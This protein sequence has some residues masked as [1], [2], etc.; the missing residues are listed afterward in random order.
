VPGISSGDGCLSFSVE[1]FSSAY[2]SFLPGP[3]DSGLIS[4]TRKYDEKTSVSP[5]RPFRD[6]R[7]AISL[8]PYGDDIGA[9]INKRTQS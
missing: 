5:E 7:T 1:A 6:S 3:A 9:A 2:L 4:T 8:L